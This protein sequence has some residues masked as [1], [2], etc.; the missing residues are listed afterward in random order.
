MSGHCVVLSTDCQCNAVQS[1]QK[2]CSPDDFN[3]VA[4]P[5]ERQQGSTDRDLLRRRKATEEKMEKD[6]SCEN[7]QGVGNRF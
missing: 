3:A 7:K 6:F 5:A 2:Q 1:I 4:V